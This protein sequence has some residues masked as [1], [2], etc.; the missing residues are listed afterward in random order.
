MGPQVRALFDEQHVGAVRT[1]AEQ[2]QHRGP[3]DIAR[4]IAGRAGK[5]RNVR[6]GDPVGEPPQPVRRFG[7]LGAHAATP[8]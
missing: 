3:A 2:H 6:P 8:K 7:P 5:R 4:R 1:L